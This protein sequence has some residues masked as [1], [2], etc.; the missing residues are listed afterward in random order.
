MKRLRIKFLIV[1][2]VSLLPHTSFSAEHYKAGDKLYVAPTS[3]MNLRT[4]P[5]L[6]APII[7]K[8]DFNMVVTVQPDSLP[9]TP[10]QIKVSDFNEGNLLLKGSWVKVSAKGVTGYA[11]D[12]MLSR[13]P[14]I[15]LKII[16]EESYLPTL[17]GAPV[18]KNQKRSSVIEGHKISYETKTTTYPKVLVM[19]STFLDDCYNEEY[20]FTTTFNEAYWLIARMMRYADA[21]QDTKIM[22]TASG[23]KITF[24]SCT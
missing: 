3:G 23:A 1:I 24:Y 18:V 19:K 13:Y 5:S 12:G 22:K 14:G 20:T 8:L 17:F 7:R 4:A 11:F 9:A 15:P 10:A 2:V 6:S 16:Q 21:A